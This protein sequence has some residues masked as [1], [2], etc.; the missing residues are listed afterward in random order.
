M[1][2]ELVPKISKCFGRSPLPVLKWDMAAVTKVMRRCAEKHVP[3]G[4]PYHSG[5]DEEFLRLVDVS[6]RLRELEIRSGVPNMDGAYHGP[7]LHIC[8][9]WGLIRQVEFTILDFLKA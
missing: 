8:S 7:V 6:E 5:Y 2:S 4:S 1:P 9:K 3:W